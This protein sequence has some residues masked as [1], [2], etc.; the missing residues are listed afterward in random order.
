[1]SV[2]IIGED[3][4]SLDAPFEDEEECL[5]RDTI[6]SLPAEE[7]WSVHQLFDGVEI[8]GWEKC[9]K[10]LE[11][12]EEAIT[13]GL[14]GEDMLQKLFAYCA[15]SNYLKLEGSDIREADEQ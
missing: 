3:G 14:P 12:I 8:I 5:L 6:D 13:W 2:F 11:E 7:F 10:L 4:E 9:E 15:N 1:M